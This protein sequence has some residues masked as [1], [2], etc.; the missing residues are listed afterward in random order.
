[1][2]KLE[3]ALQVM[4]IGFSVVMFTLLL[5]YGLLHLFSI[6]FTRN[7]REKFKV[8][9]SNTG[10]V[11]VIKNADDKRL[12]AAIIAAVYRYMQADSMLASAGAGKINFIV[13]PVDNK[14]DDNWQMTGRRRLLQGRMDL[15]T[16]RRKKYHENI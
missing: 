1:M 12:T 2:D 6:I 15:E 14:N 9:V 5:L 3:F 16:I 8:E 10:A 4:V 11:P 7:K 13:K